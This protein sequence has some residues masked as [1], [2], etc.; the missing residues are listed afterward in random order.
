MLRV[1]IALALLVCAAGTFLASSGAA[2]LGPVYRYDARHD[3]VPDRLW[4]GGL[5]FH[6]NYREEPET[7][8]GA[9][10]IS[11]HGTDSVQAPVASNR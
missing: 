5:P 1:A 8:P 3:L 4:D 2:I 10:P 9:A 6:A 7:V 11:D